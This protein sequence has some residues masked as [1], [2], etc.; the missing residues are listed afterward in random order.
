MVRCVDSSLA[1]QEGNWD[2]E[3]VNMCGIEMV[4]LGVRLCREESRAWKG[5]SSLGEFGR[6]KGLEVV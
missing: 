6:A 4:V 2:I 3:G 1:K 5:R